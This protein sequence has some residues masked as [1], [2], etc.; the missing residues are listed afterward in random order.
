MIKLSKISK[1]MTTSS[2]ISK[3]SFKKMIS[4]NKG[5]L[6]SKISKELKSAGMS[7]LLNKNEINK[8]QAIKAV[9]HLQKKGQVSKYKNASQMWHDSATEQY[10]LD[11]MAIQEEKQR[12]IRIGIAMDTAEDARLIERGINPYDPKSVMGKSM[13]QEIAEEQEQRAKRS[14][15]DLQKKKSHDNKKKPGISKPQMVDFSKISDM[16]IG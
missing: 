4:G 1:F 16:D 14:A 9:R 12:N 8:D 13:A 5:Y 15:K 10:E 11:E 3:N 6:P 7:G 2:K